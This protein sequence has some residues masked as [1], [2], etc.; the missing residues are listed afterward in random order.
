MKKSVLLSAA[1]LISTAVALSVSS[2]S[3]VMEY[4]AACCPV[5]AVRAGEIVHADRE[6][7][8]NPGF[9]TGSL[10]P[11]TTNN[12]VVDTI[13]PHSGTYCACDVGNFWIDQTFDSVPGSEVQ[14]ITFWSR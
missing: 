7:L 5:G 11:W 4:E 12:W 14:S 9:E 8:E 6:V 10:P 2:G 1:G 3:F 13:Y